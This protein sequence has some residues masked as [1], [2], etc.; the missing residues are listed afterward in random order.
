MLPV[1]SFLVEA[2][3]FERARNLNFIEEV[4][5]FLGASH[6]L[7]VYHLLLMSNVGEDLFFDSDCVRST[8]T[9]YVRHLVLGLLP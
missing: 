1:L 6:P 8:Q 2:E 9:A 7:H 4:S 5:S 3:G